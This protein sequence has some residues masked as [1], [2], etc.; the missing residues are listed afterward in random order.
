MLIS[1]LGKAEV[2]LDKSKPKEKSLRPLRCTRFFENGTP[3]RSHVVNVIAKHD[4]NFFRLF[5]VS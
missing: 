2:S 1:I 4:T 5:F 3:Q